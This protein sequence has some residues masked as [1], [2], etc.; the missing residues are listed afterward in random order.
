M[1]LNKTQ[2]AVISGAFLLI[3]L[4]LL[5]NTNL[6]KKE[7]VKSSEHSSP[8]STET[9]AMIESAKSTLNAG[10][11]AM[12]TKLEEATK[13][14]GQE[15]KKVAFENLINQWDSLRKPTV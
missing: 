13:T 6:P 12:V 15:G 10:Q 7:E 2:I 8:N 9:S 11:K 4:L 1:Y 14:S 3:V 5:A